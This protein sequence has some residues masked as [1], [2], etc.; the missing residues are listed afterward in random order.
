MNFTTQSAAVCHK[1]SQS[2]GLGD[3]VYADDGWGVFAVAD[4]QGT[5][6]GLRTPAEIFVQVLQANASVL[7]LAFKDV[8][9]T[10]PDP[11]KVRRILVAIY[12]R[13]SQAIRREFRLQPGEDGPMASATTVVLGQGHAVVA[14]LGLTRAL[15]VRYDKV[16]PLTRLHAVDVQGSL[17]VDQAV[18]DAPTHHVLAQGMGQP[19]PIRIDVSPLRLLDG[20]CFVL[21]TDG[22]H[23]HLEHAELLDCHAGVATTDQL[24]EAFAGLSARRSDDDRSCVVVDVEDEDAIEEDDAPT[25]AS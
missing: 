11:A 4:S 12:S 25:A 2:T 21:M 22:I 13:A 19:D 16:T 18:S 23:A 14:H 3:A 1:G 9:P 6:E 20:D 10:S 15:I 7:S 24:A 8:T 17:G 5:V